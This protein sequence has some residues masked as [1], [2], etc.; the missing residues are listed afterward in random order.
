MKKFALLFVVLLSL[1][2]V[3]QPQ[4]GATTPTVCVQGKACI[5]VETADEAG[6]QALG[7]MFRES[8]PENSG[9]LFIFPDSSPRSFWMKNTLIPLDIMW[10]DESKKIAGI[11][12]NVQPCKADPCPSYPSRKPVKYVLE[13]NA[14]FA[15]RKGIKENDSVEFD[16]PE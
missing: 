8:L 14:G 6:E 7:L 9:M 2:C 16:L 3:Q 1:G 5:E 15:G 12:E 4:Q 13:V 10:I 11:T